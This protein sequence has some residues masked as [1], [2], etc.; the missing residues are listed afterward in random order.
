LIKDCDDGFEEMIKTVTV[1]ELR[2]NL[3]LLL[4]DVEGGQSITIVREGRP[5][6]TIG[7]TIVPRDLVT[8]IRHDPALRLQDFDAGQPL[9]GTGSVEWLIAERERDRS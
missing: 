1:E 6:G 3:E 4:S 7:P 2:E 9:Q 8:V 5:I